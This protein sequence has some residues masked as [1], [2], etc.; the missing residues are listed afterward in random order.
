[1]RD[2]EADTQAGKEVLFIVM[3]VRLETQTD[4]L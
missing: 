4:N 3:D 2:T 1:M